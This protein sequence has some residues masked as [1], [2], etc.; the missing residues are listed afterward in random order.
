[1]SPPPRSF[2][3]RPQWF[4]CLF[5]SRRTQLV[6]IFFTWQSAGAQTDEQTIDFGIN[7]GQ[8]P[9]LGTL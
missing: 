9:D 3:F 6:D 1:M 5:V 8:V 7:P 2:C 4:V